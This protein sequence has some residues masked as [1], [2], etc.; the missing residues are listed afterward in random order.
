MMTIEGYN[1]QN[2]RKITE[3]HQYISGRKIAV[4]GVGISNRPLIR[5]IHSL[6]AVITAF[7]ALPEDDAVLTKTKAAFKEE[8]IILN[9]SCGENYLSNLPDGGFDMI[10]RTPKMRPDVPEILEAVAGGSILTSEMEVFMDLCPARIFAVTGSDGKTTTTTLI[11][12]ILKEAGY[13]VYV[14]GNIGT[15]LLDQIDKILDTDMVVLELSSFQLMSMRKSADVAVVTN[16][17]PNHLDVHKSYQEYIDTK[18]NIFINQSFSGRLVLN[19]ENK[20]TRE[21][22]ANARGKVSYFT[23][24]F[25]KQLTEKTSQLF[26]HAYVRD[27]ILMYKSEGIEH[28]IVAIND[29]VIPGD[30]NVENYLAAICASMPFVTQYNISAVAKSFGGVEHRIELVRTLDGV[31]YYNSSIDTSPNRTINTMN[32]LHSR[33]EHGVLIAGGADKKCDYNGL[34]KAILSVCNR[35]ILCGSNA[36]LIHEI[37]DKEC[38]G[39]AFDVIEVSEYAEAVTK[40]KELAQK[41][42][43]VILSPVGTSYDRFRHFEERGN[44]FK[45]LVTEL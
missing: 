1:M 6:G 14:G 42:E 30:H 26:D 11:S 33:N 32:A 18:T 25:D 7:D 27:G 3:F 36:S 2:N 10:F 24:D 16:I 20:I 21:M 8:G 9:W 39:V 29:I 5:Y 34:G 15:P 31:R 19:G 23:W 40:S 41:G 17:T 38:D 44:L 12:L 43:I 13:T 45:K 4:L 37:L 35:I 28:R 22:A